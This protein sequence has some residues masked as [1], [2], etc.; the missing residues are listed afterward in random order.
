M[1]LKKFGLTRKVNYLLQCMDDWKLRKNP[2]DSML[3]SRKFYL[4][5]RVRVENILNMLADDKSR[6]VWGGGSA[7]LYDEDASQK[8]NVFFKRPVFCG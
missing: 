6:M 2:S 4:E 8:G 5:N 1:F 7:I 3:E